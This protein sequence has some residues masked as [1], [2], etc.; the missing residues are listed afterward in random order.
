MLVVFMSGVTKVVRSGILFLGAAV[1]PY[2]SV[3]R[4]MA[5]RKCMVREFSI[6]EDDLDW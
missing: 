1:A 5:D 6:D 4:V 3:R 2:E